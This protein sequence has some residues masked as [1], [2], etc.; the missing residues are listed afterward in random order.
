MTLDGDRGCRAAGQGDPF[1]AYLANFRKRGSSPA[2]SPVLSG[3]GRAT[4][5][6]GYQSSNVL[7]SIWKAKGPS[8]VSVSPPAA[9]AWGT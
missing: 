7:G 4:M 5:I 6:V 8:N 1:A 2:S 9:T 3:P